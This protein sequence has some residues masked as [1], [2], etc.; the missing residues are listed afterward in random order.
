MYNSVH[1]VE[2]A[3]VNV[4]WWAFVTMLLT[5]GFVVS[6]NVSTTILLLIRV[7]ESP[8]SIFNGVRTIISKYQDANLRVLM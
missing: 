1:C 7:P 6:D 3:Q 2:L 5:S 8:I 4:Q